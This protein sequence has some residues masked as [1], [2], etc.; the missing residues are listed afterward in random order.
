MFVFSKERG[1]GKDEKTSFLTLYHMRQ[2]N[3]AATPN[4]WKYGNKY[5]I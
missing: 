3:L 4:E 5:L 2:Q 1:G